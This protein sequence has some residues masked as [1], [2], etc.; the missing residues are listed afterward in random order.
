MMGLE[1]Q[2]A[3]REPWLLVVERLW[4]TDRDGCGELERWN[5]RSP[6]NLA[7]PANGQ[8]G[9]VEQRSN[10]DFNTEYSCLNIGRNETIILCNQQNNQKIMA[11]NHVSNDQRIT[12]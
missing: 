6:I 9:D 11:Q 8:G 3:G 2:L 4:D 5:S 10:L 1:K 12:V 7:G